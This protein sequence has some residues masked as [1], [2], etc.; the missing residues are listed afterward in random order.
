MECAPDISPP[1]SGTIKGYHL[2][3]ENVKFYT[4]NYLYSSLI[5]APACPCYVF[6]TTLVMRGGIDMKRLFLAL[7]VVGAL[8]SYSCSSD[9]EYYSYEYLKND[10]E[11]VAVVAAVDVREVKAVG[12]MGD[13]EAGYVRYLIRC[14]GIDPLKGAIKSNQALAYYSVAEKGYDPEGYSG[15][16]IV[17]LNSLFDKDKRWFLSELET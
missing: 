8:L 5:D 17:F 11:Q 13:K 10:Y 2:L 1:A 15:N 9:K 12:S 16:R 7:C 6:E 4:G 14:Q 3:S